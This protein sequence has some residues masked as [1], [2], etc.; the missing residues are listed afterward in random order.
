MANRT[1][2]HIVR[3]GVAPVFNAAASG[4]TFTPGDQVFLHVKN[5]GG[6]GITCTVAA[7][8]GEGGLTL[9]PYVTPSI[10]ATT[11]ELIFG[12]FPSSLFANV[13]DGFAHITWSATTSVTW[14]VFT[15]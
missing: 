13:S 6:S 7:V 14:G 2:Q 4:D 5:G 8:G 9:T 11:G 1:P 15:L 3:A 12:P 10:A